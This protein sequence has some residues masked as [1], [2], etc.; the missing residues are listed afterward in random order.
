VV[1]SVFR[2]N[3]GVEGGLGTALFVDVA[4]PGPTTVWVEGSRFERNHELHVEWGAWVTGG[5]VYIGDH[6]GPSDLTVD[7]VD[8][9]F[10][11]NTGVHMAH[12]ALGH[13]DVDRPMEVRITGGAFWRGDAPVP[14]LAELWEGEAAPGAAIAAFLLQT[15]WAAPRVTLTDVDVGAGPTAN[16][17][18]VFSACG[19]VYAGLVSG[20]LDAVAGQYC[21]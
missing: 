15:T 17:G 13:V 2:D 1:D 14:F 11:G 7:L 16:A 21:P 20:E 10:D 5:A 18:Q 8:D 4:A 12:L 19:T 3:V 9:V 6:A